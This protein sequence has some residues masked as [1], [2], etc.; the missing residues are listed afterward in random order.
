MYMENIEEKIKEI[1]RSFRLVMNGVA[2]QSMRAGEGD[3]QG[4]S[5]GSCIMEGKYPRMQD[6]C[7]DDYACTG[8]IA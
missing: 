4:L 3:R 5:S 2:A 7:H 1:K 8:D 6:T